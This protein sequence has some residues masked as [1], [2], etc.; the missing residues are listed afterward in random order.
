MLEIVRRPS[1]SSWRSVA[2][3]C[4]INPAT[5]MTTWQRALIRGS[6]WYLAAMRA[7]DAI[8]FGRAAPISSARDST[9]IEF[10]VAPSVTMLSLN[11]S[12]NDRSMGCRWRIRYSTA[13]AS[14]GPSSSVDRNRCVRSDTSSDI[15]ANPGVSISTMSRSRSDG[16][17][18]STYEIASASW[19]PSEN[20]SSRSVRRKRSSTGSPR[21][22]IAVTRYM[23][24]LR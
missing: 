13:S 9:P 14:P 15:D 17:S 20:S 2:P 11:A 24:L 6:D 23:W 16:H 19:S 18:T 5:G 22:G 12:R 3:A 21:Y 1:A 8:A 4:A 10:T 7:A